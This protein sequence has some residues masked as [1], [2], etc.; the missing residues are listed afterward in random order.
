LE[1]Y[2]GLVFPI[3][4][5]AYL[6]IAGDNPPFGLE[7]SIATVIIFLI[8]LIGQKNFSWSLA[9]YSNFLRMQSS[10]R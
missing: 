5:K 4:Y 9:T 3:T 7:G 10:A 2:L 1:E 6:L 8:F